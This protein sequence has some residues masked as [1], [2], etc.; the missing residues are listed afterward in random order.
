MSSDFAVCVVRRHLFM[1][2]T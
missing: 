2:A 1:N